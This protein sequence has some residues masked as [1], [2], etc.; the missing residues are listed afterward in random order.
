MYLVISPS[1]GGFLLA[2]SEFK[3]NRSVVNASQSGPKSYSACNVSYGAREL[4]MEREREGF[5]DPERIRRDSVIDSLHGER[6]AVMFTSWVFSY[7][8]GVGRGPGASLRCWE[9][10]HGSGWHR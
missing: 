10:H 5:G 1:Y 3:E 2:N 7:D 9:G 6:K 4:V 8:R